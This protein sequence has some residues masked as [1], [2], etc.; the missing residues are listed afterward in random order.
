MSQ[1]TLGVTYGENSSVSKAI[2][3][4]KEFKAFVQDNKIKLINNKS[5]SN[6]SF[7]FAWNSNLNLNLALRNAD[8]IDIHLDSNNTLYAKV[9]DTYD[10]NY[11]EVDPKIII[12]RILQEKDIILPYYSVINIKV[13]EQV[14]KN[15]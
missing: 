9:V 14:W 12:P 7:Y 15:Y 3:N 6:S 5:I 13:P 4:S 1:N 10:F 8:I 2:S 11:G